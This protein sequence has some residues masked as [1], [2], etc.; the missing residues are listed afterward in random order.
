[1]AVA[2]LSQGAY[3]ADAQWAVGAAEV[4]AALV[5]VAVPPRRA[6][7]TAPVLGC[8]LL[9]GWSLLR[10]LGGSGPLSGVR[11]ALLVLGLAVAFTV[12]CRLTDEDRA[13]LTHGIL[14]LGGVVALAGWVGVVWHVSPYALSNDGVWRATSTLTYANALAAVLGCLALVALGTVA[15]L[16]WM[17][18]AER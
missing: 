11:P 7:M 12:V 18:V 14:A 6:V 1:M 8:L 4:G 13:L 16:L 15:S 5:T 10:G 9:A 3:Y 17:L 2:L